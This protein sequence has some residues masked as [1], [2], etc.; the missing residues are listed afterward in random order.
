[1]STSLTVKKESK[2]MNPLVSGLKDCK[3]AFIITFIFAFGVNLLN[4]ITPLYSLQVLDRV[5]GSQNK[6]T[7]LMLTLIIFFVYMSHMLLQVA[8]SFVLIK[9]SEWLD[10]RISPKLFAHAVATAAIKPSLGGS[11]VIREF[12]TIKQFLTSVGINSLF[13]AP[14]SIIYI[15]VLFLIHPYIGWITIIGVIIALF[16]AMIN[17]YSVND[18]LSASNESNIKGH[19]MAEISTRNAETIQAMGLLNRIQHRWSLINAHTLSL[20]SKAS[21]R[22]GVVSNVTRFFRH[23]IQVS[24]TC[25]GAYLVISTNPPEMT[26]GYMIASSIIVG[27]ALAPFDAAVD[28]WKQASS[29]MKS[30]KKIN[31]FLDNKVH[32]EEG[33]EISNPEGK[34]SAENLFFAHPSSNPS[35]PKQILKGLNFT[36]ESGKSLAIIGANAAGKST[37]SRLLVG[38]WKPTSG[39]IRLDDID[40]L[41]WKRETFGKHVGYLPQGVQLFNGTIKENIARMDAHPN[42]EDVIKAAKLAGAHE[43]ISKLPEGYETD[44]GISGSSLSGGQR[45]RVG[46]ARAFFGNPKVIILDEP[47][48]N[49][50]DK[51]EKALLESLHNA[52][53]KSITSIVVSHRPSILSFVDMI[54]VLQDGMIVAYGPREEVMARFSPQNKGETK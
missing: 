7:L 41:S 5:L 27:R 12:T 1:M 25:T 48:A 38:V 53:E 4:L 17:A 50:D 21:Y 23:L 6:Y 32:S 54:M 31:S 9:I 43:L 15:I 16:M 39:H 40:V 3:Q 45:Q 10:K 34:I 49:L 51:G 2:E 8:R 35:Q 33:L 26:A 52:K 46:L 30:Y 24:V 29:A 18:S 28:V 37:L 22:N 13:D 11:Q 19:H 20:N 44:I 42:S 14:W 47:N 36:L